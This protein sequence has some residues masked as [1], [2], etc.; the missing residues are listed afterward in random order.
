M[1]ERKK[2]VIIT[3][4]SASWKTTVQNLMI[5]SGKWKKPINFTTREPRNDLE[6]DE[7]IFLS[8]NNFLTKLGKWDFLESTGW[9]WDFYG[10]S[11]ILPE[12]DVCIVLDPIGRAQM[13]AKVAMWEL[14]DFI[15]KFVYLDI[16]KD[17][18]NKRL[19][20]RGDNK[21]Q[22]KKRNRDF[23]WFAPTPACTIINCNDQSPDEIL[24]KITNELNQ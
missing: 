9:Y 16:S 2:M 17:V 13:K 22:I 8:R 7:Y 1:K 15:V 3:G 10:I 4:P 14:D 20:K 6:L 24:T 5:D 19:R 18:Q 23:D 21:V 12:G 11:R